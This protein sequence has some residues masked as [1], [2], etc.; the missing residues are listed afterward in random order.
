MSALRIEA[1]TGARLTAHLPDVARL[2]IE[3]FRSFPYLYDGD[4]EAEARYISGFAASPHAVIVGA[5]DGEEV[6]GASTAAPLAT[7][8]DDV[9][10]PFRARGDDLAPIF[11]FGESVLRSSY[12]G[13]GIGVRFFE[14][15]EAHAR[16]RGAVAAAFCAVVR[17]DDHPA[18]PASYVPLDGF[19]RKRGYA[20]VPGLICRMGWREVGHGEE[21]RKAMQFWM[22]RLTS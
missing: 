8:M 7:Q 13:R 22:K 5:F 4:L 11:Y 2:R 14:E 12:R 20:P 18:R 19:W 6:V 9:T 16:R 15:R 17:A 21:T 3:V 10:E 1:L